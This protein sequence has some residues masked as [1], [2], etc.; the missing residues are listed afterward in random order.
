[1][2]GSNF[3]STNGP[4]NPVKPFYGYLNLLI[5]YLRSKAANKCWTYVFELKSLQTMQKQDEYNDD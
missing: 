5:Y 4:N 3:D 1:M 2:Y